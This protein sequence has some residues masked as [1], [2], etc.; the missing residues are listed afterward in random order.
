MYVDADIFYIT[1]GIEYN[2]C[3]LQNNVLYF[4]W[5]FSLMDVQNMYNF[6]DDS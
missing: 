1:K 4:F 3:L 6:K 5:V 2:V